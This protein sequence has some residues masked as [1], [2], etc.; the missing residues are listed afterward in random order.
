MI[1]TQVFIVSLHFCTL[2]LTVIHG[3]CSSKY[4]LDLRIYAKI[5]SS[6]ALKYPCSIRT[7]TD[8]SEYSSFSIARRTVS[9]C[10][11][12]T[13]GCSGSETASTGR[14]G[15]VLQTGRGLFCQKCPGTILSQAGTARQRTFYEFQAPVHQVA[16]CSQQFTVMAVDEF[17]PCEVRVSLLRAVGN[18]EIPDGIRIVAFQYILYPD[19]PVFACGYL[20]SFERQ[21]LAGYDHIR[22]LQAAVCTAKKKR[23]QYDR[24]ERYIVLAVCVVLPAGVPEIE[25]S[26]PFRRHR[27]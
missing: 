18:E 23:G 9:V 2:L 21:V 5:V 12:S 24:M 16:V 10:C 7:P 11:L 6:A 17:C 13:A 8:G 19:S 22:K 1:C 20:F 14:S 25:K 3:C 27:V 15:I 26:S 4:L